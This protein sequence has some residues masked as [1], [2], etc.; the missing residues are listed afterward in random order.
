MLS[1][2]ERNDM[3][4]ALEAM[5]LTIAKECIEKLLNHAAEIDAGLMNLRD[6]A[7]VSSHAANDFL[8]DVLGTRCK[9]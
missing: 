7:V 9:Y 1:I 3:K 8:S 5:G 2:R 4:N 6:R